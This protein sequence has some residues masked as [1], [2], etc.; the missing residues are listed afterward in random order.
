MS[1][2]VVPHVF[3]RPTLKRLV[4]SADGRA[5]IEPRSHVRYLSQPNGR[6][7]LAA[8]AFLLSLSRTIT[9]EATL[10]QYGRVVTDFMCVLEEANGGRGIPLESLNDDIL[11]RWRISQLQY[12]G[13]SMK[14]FRER[15]TIVLRLILHAQNNG[16]IPRIL[17]D[18]QGDHIVVRWEGQKMRHPLHE[19]TGAKSQPV[20]RS[21]ADLGL[22]D[23]EIEDQSKS[24]LTRRC[25]RLL[26]RVMRSAALRRSEVVRLTVDNIPSKIRLERLRRRIA[27]GTAEPIVSFR[28]KSSKKGGEREISLPL[29]LALQLRE[30]IDTERAAL[31][32]SMGISPRDMRLIFVSQ[33]SG[34]GL[35]PQSVT[36]L[37]KRAAHSTALRLGRPDLA[38]ISPHDERHRGITD[39][40]RRALESGRSPAETMFETLRYARLARL[41]T[42]WTYVHLAQEE[43]H[44]STRPPKG[45]VKAVEREMHELTM[46]ERV[47]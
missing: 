31:L 39:F 27:S 43:M 19:G 8:S 45:D 7:H 18:R 4:L 32:R 1:V 44:P 14:V 26:S 47:Y 13:I 20:I 16:W 35:T 17:G 24:A 42:A 25:R 3:L 10:H 22:L 9:S 11:T 28:I 12:R 29:S 23:A 30:Y 21:H 6:M 2:K 5:D 38:G 33:K 36:N 34:R 15:L 37:Y 41:S 40:A 46:M